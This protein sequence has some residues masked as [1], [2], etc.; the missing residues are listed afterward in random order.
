MF[1]APTEFEA[2]PTFSN[3]FTHAKK[4]TLPSVITEEYNTFHN[5]F[6]EQNK[7]YL[8]QDEIRKEPT[9]LFLRRAVEENVNIINTFRK[10]KQVLKDR[11]GAFQEFSPVPDYGATQGYYAGN[12]DLD[13]F[14][15]LED[16]LEGFKLGFDLRGATLTYDISISWE[17]SLYYVGNSPKVLDYN[18]TGQLEFDIISANGG[19]FLEPKE[20]HARQWTLQT[21]KNTSEPLTNF[22]YGIYDKVDNYTRQNRKSFAITKIYEKQTGNVFESPGKQWHNFLG[23]YLRLPS[24]HLGEFDLRHSEPQQSMYVLT[25][26]SNIASM[27]NSWYQT[28]EQVASREFDA[29][30]NWKGKNYPITFSCARDTFSLF[31]LISFSGSGSLNFDFFDHSPIRQT[32]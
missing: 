9:D 5:Q 20:R 29:Q 6:L 8:N 4:S 28:P 11:G 18:F 26:N 2:D 3:Y 22:L 16:E 14:L 25:W 15:P 12:F 21:H 7:T 13:Y 23:Y 19:F 27:Q 17:D 1:N 31:N 24:I 30:I 32:N 10:Q